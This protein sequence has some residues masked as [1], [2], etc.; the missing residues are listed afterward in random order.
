MNTLKLRLREFKLSGI[1]NSLEERLSLAKEK[2]LSYIQ[3]LELLMEDET[4]N[5]RDNSYRKRYSKA[6]LPAR[7]T[8][9]DFDFGFQPSINK[10]VINDCLTCNFIKEKK[11]IVFIGNPGTGKTH[12]SIAIGIKS[13]M[14]GHKVL[15]TSVTEMLQALNAAKAD[16]SYYQK[17]NYYLSPDLLILDELG[18]KKL[19]NYSADDFFEI[20]SKRYEQGSLIIT[21]NKSFEQWTDIFADNILANAIIDRV[22]HYSTVIMIKGPSY[23]KKDQKNGGDKN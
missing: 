18:F 21:T 23:R 10:R 20:I 3:F 7:K 14:K 6:K 8:I 2:N 1:Y 22:V 15:F 5:R 16:N 13:L 12:L 4:N 19:P 17:V 11:N 9:E